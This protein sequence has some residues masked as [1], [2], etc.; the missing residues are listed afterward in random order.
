MHPYL[1]CLHY[2]FGG[3]L[4]YCPRLSKHFSSSAHS[5]VQQGGSTIFRPQVAP[6]RFAWWISETPPRWH[7]WRV[8][9]GPKTSMAKER[10]VSSFFSVVNLSYRKYIWHYLTIFIFEDCSKGTICLRGIEAT[11]HRLSCRVSGLPV[12]WSWFVCSDFDTE[13][14]RWIDQTKSP[15]ACHSIMPVGHLKVLQSGFGPKKSRQCTFEGQ[16][17][18]HLSNIFG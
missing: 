12:I 2:F 17:L 1:P 4:Y 11:N 9:L 16:I 7:C 13:V 14:P 5:G 15:V 8:S 10:V 6:C 3:C 18:I